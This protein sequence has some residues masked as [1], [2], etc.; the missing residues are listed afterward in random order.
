MTLSTHLIAKRDKW[1]FWLLF[2]MAPDQQNQYLA[3]PPCFPSFPFHK[4]EK[5]ECNLSQLF[6]VPFCAVAYIFLF[7]FFC[8]T[9]LRPTDLVLYLM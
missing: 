3:H 2:L 6:K 5:D 4:K 1:C 9:R 8:L 7:S